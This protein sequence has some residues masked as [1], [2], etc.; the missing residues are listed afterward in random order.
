[1][2]LRGTIRRSDNGP[3]GTEEDVKRRLSDAFPGVR[4]V[5]QAEAPPGLAQAQIPFLL[6]VWQLIFGVKTPYP[7]YHGYFEP[8][9]G[10]VVEF[11]F[12]AKEP[13]YWITA[14]SYGMTT[15]LDENFDRLFG[16]T[17]WKIVYPRF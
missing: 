6:R 12:Q 1:M 2:S 8:G 14:T 10:G 5:Y 16:A 7:N 9:N 11:Y 17:G 15:G 4:F 3:L 13:V